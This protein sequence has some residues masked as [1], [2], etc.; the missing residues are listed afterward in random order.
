MRPSIAP[1]PGVVDGMAVP[2]SR[3]GESAQSL[4]NS[5]ISETPALP[6]DRPRHRFEEGSMGGRSRVGRRE[7]ARPGDDCRIYKGRGSSGANAMAP[8]NVSRCCRDV[9]NAAR[10]CHAVG[11][12]SV[13]HSG[14]CVLEPA[15][16][17]YKRLESARLPGSLQ[18]VFETG[19]IRVVL[20]GI[21][22]R[23]VFERSQGKG[24]RPGASRAHLRA[25][26][27]T[28]GLGGPG[29]WGVL[30]ASGVRPARSGVEP[31]RRH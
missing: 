4:W 14:M 2:P 3:G 22:R 28:T 18:C 23:T 16:S 8:K 7:V 15:L 13:L 1:I 26:C 9:P 30:N 29:R 27:R 11:L 25:R 19:R 6:R 5:R 10:R 24:D 12:A 31:T 17:R 21:Y 20:R